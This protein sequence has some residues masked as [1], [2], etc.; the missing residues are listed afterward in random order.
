MLLFHFVLTFLTFK[1]V[2]KIKSLIK[3]PHITL[4]TASHREQKV[5]KVEF[6]YNREVKDVL[7]SKTDARWSSDMN[8]WFIPTEKFVLNE[9]FTA[10]NPV[11]FID[12]SAFKKQPVTYENPD[13]TDFQKMKKPI[14]N[15]PEGYLGK[16]IQQRYSENTIKT[17]THYFRDFISAFKGRDLDSISKEEINSYILKLIREKDISASQQNQRINAIKFYYEKILNRGKEYY[18]IDRP[19]KERKLPDVLSK[20]E[21]GAMLKV[22]TNLKHK[23]L[24]AV[25]YS[26]GLRR[27]EIINLKLEDIDS[28]RMLIKIRGA[29]GKKDRYVQLSPS[30]LDMLRSYYNK[31]KPVTWLFEGRSGMKYSAESISQV[32]KS[33]ARKANINKRVYPHILRHSYATHNLEQG[34]DIRYIQEWLGHESIKTTEKYTHVSKNSFNFKNPID[35]II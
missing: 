13:E 24:I 31:E 3:K 17:Y 21:I 7:K 12:Y 8:S 14:L 26:C 1:T 10:M 23:C 15:I 29:K 18:Q 32:I 20:E 33:A 25:I 27:S 19:R 4:S 22:A 16:L 28:K 6:T 34:I 11:A 2:N 5:V 35:D 9:F 30:I